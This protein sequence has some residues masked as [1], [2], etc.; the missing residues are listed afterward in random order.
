MA[1]FTAGQATEEEIGLLMTGGA[2]HAREQA[3][4]VEAPGLAEGQ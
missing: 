4:D 3:I 2:A 1:M